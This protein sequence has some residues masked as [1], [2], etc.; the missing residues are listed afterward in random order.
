MNQILR[1]ATFALL[2]QDHALGEASLEFVWARE[3]RKVNR[4]HGNLLMYGLISL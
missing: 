4:E 3:S 1:S 2:L